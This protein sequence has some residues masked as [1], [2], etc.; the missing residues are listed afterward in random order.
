MAVRALHV[1]LAAWV[2]LPACCMVACSSDVLLEL[3]AENTCMH[4]RLPMTPWPCVGL[5][6]AGAAHL[7]SW[8]HV[9]LPTHFVSHACSD[10][11][12]T[13]IWSSSVLSNYISITQGDDG[14]GN[15]VRQLQQLIQV[16]LQRD[17]GTRC[18]RAMVSMIRVW[19][20][21]SACLGYLHAV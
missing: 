11:V 1:L 17:G 15:E 13:G 4:A 5:A 3:P 20:S 16:K 18:R 14:L 19:G 8:S 12:A 2:P 6:C 21:W 7:I 9:P 10:G